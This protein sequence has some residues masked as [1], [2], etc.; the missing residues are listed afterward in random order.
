MRKM[1]GRRS[2]LHDVNINHQRLRGV[3]LVL[4]GSVD[5]L[6]RRLPRCPRATTLQLAQGRLAEDVQAALQRELGPQGWAFVTGASDTFTA[7]SVTAQ[8]A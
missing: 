3:A 6:H 7:P 1:V 8:A 4:F 5:G 2:K